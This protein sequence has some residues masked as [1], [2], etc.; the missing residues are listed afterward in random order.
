M[1]WYNKYMERR[2]TYIAI[3]LKSFYASVEC[4][5]RGLNPLTSNLVV[6][7][8]ERTDKTICLA[9]S[10]SLKAYGISGR[11]RL[12]EVRKRVNE[13]NRERQ[14]AIG[15]R[16]FRGSSTEADELNSDPYLKLDFL[17]AEPRMSLYMEY[18]RRI[19][20]IYL[21]YLAPEDIHVYSI[22]EIMADVTSY[23]NTYRMSAHDLTML[24]I[25]DILRETGITATGGIGTNLYLCKVAM[26]IVAKHIPADENGVRIAYLDEET[27]RRT[28]WTHQP[29]TDFWRVGRG[30]AKRLQEEGI[31]TMGDIARCSL[32]SITDYYNEDL[33]YRMFGIN[34]ELL[35]DHAWGIEPCTME[36][37]KSFRPASESLGSGQVLTRP[38]SYEE[39]RIIVREMADDLAQKLLMQKLMCDQ[40]VLYVGYDIENL[41]KEDAYKGEVTTDFYGRTL[42]KAVHGSEKL[43]GYTSSS[44]KITDA[45]MAL[46]ERLVNDRL[47]IR[48]VNVAMLH[49]KNE[50]EAL[51]SMI[52]RQDSLFEDNDREEAEMKK[53]LEETAKEKKA[54]EAINAI[55]A[56]FGKTSVIKVRDLQEGAT[57][58][59]R[60][61][62]VGGHKA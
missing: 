32:G 51:S 53:R 14:R 2:R 37:I 16:E 22:D 44:R 48:R 41:Q 50:K 8:E 18:S 26:D 7:D 10:P 55:R 13:I 4:Q 57:T 36:A 1:F 49:T 42:P 33:L 9:V 52:I 60:S 11:A 19:Y 12:F 56:R 30:I 5:E 3:D 34:A 20:E 61:R 39:G 62:Q 58:I 15:W 25:H 28:L 40:V 38:Y 6:A 21:R 47:S 27:Y 35:I 17:A 59:L 43:G 24:I 45:L 54:Q 29:L 46:Y 23:L 31:L